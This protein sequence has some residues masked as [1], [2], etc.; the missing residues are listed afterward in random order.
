MEDGSDAAERSHRVGSALA[1]PVSSRLVLA[2]EACS[3]HPATFYGTVP[4]RV[5]ESLRGPC[6]QLCAERFLLADLL[7]YQRGGSFQVGFPAGLHG[8]AVVFFRGNMNLLH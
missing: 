4:I 2:G 7:F 6:A 5:R 1:E 8:S 3:D